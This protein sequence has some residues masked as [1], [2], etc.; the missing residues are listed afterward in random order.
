[1]FG[2]LFN[3]IFVFFVDEVSIPKTYI[4]YI[5]S[6]YNYG[7]LIVGVH[8]KTFHWYVNCHNPLHRGEVL[9]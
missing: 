4:R 8:I 6:D 5:F 9:L 7:I 3:F 1:M 2:T